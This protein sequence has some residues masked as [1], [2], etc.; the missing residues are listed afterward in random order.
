MPPPPPYSLSNTPRGHTLAGGRPRVAPPPPLGPLFLLVFT[1]VQTY[2]C[3]RLAPLRLK[4][5]LGC[6]SLPLRTPS[7]T[8]VQRTEAPYTS[9]TLKWRGLPHPMARGMAMPSRSPSHHPLWFLRPRSRSAQPRHLRPLCHLLGPRPCNVLAAVR[10][11]VAPSTH[12]TGG[13]GL[14]MRLVC[15]LLKGQSNVFHVLVVH[16][17]IQADVMCPFYFWLADVISQSIDGAVKENA[18]AVK[19]RKRR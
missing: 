13:T 14:L 1:W 2:V 12:A 5:L 9:S 7:A 8:Y 17:R 11:F 18:A 15:N 19:Q 16:V 4:L 10:I 3:G 6:I